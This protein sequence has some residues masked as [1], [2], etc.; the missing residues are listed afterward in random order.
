MM[1]AVMRRPMFQPRI[2]RRQTGTPSTGEMVIEMKQKPQLDDYGKAVINP[3]F[4]NFLLSTYGDR[5][6]SLLDTLLIGNTPENF[7][8][9]TGLLNEFTNFKIANEMKEKGAI[10]PKPF[11]I[12]EQ[13]LNFLERL[14]SATMPNEPTIDPRLMAEGGKVESDAVGIASGLDE[15]TPS[16]DP[17]KDGIA[18]VSPEQYVQLMNDVRGDE[19]SMEGRVQEL[20]GVVGEKDAK[21]TPLS[22]LALV[23]PVFE[24]QEKQGIAQA[25]GAD[26]MMAQAVQPQ[27]TMGPQGPMRVNQGGIVHLA[28]GT[29]GE[30][31]YSGMVG[32]FSKEQMA[33]FGL[34]GQDTVGDA[35]QAGSIFGA[36]AIQDQ[37]PNLFYNVG[38]KTTPQAEY[39][40][41]Q[42]FL[43]GPKK[44][45]MPLITAATLIK[46][47]LALAGGKDPLNVAGDTA[48]T[49]IGA[50]VQEDATQ[51]ALNDKIKMLAFNAANTKNAAL[52]KATTD[53]QI[54]AINKQYDFF[55]SKVLEQIK[56]DAKGMKNPEVYVKLDDNNQIIATEIQD[57]GSTE[58]QTKITELLNNNY[59]PVNQAFKTQKKN[60]YTVSYP[61]TK[62]GTTTIKTEILDLNTPDG[63]AKYNE[64]QNAYLKQEES[65]KKLFKFEKLSGI[66]FSPNINV[67][68][69]NIQ[70]K[71]DGG[72]VYRSTGTDEG[73][74]QSE[75]EVIG[76]S[77]DFLQD[78]DT[79]TPEYQTGGQY[80]EIAKGK[81]K[82][83]ETAME[84]IVKMYQL[85]YDNPLYF[86]IFGSGTRVGK[87]LL[88]AIDDIFNA[89]GYDVDL[90][91]ES[92]FFKPVIDEI[93]GL[94]TAIATS[95]ASVRREQT[96]RSNPVREINLVKNDLNI[97]GIGN[98]Q[99]AMDSLEQAWNEMSQKAND[100]R[101]L[102]PGVEEIDYEVPKIFSAPRKNKNDDFN[103]KQFNLIQSMMPPE[104]KDL[105]INDPDIKNAIKA[106]IEGADPTAVIERLKQL[107]G[108]E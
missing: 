67:P 11:E 41:I 22:V 16:S 87:G 44:S 60:E 20:A 99:R 78:L 28:N 72:I 27:M 106:V 2:V 69:T 74:E 3:E 23:Q 91:M 75:Q 102:L 45:K 107:K 84:N 93:M 94:E 14:K 48:T 62:D 71:K 76:V 31:V 38:D 100:Q 104:L 51:E 96:G 52:T 83:A 6:Q 18:K 85:A 54:N 10:E 5:G 82:Q 81:L 89:F 49:L 29:G 61:V 42:S 79:A 32:P 43:G 105:T 40:N 12:P 30:G 103:V 95:M 37:V 70:D 15:E 59:V 36:Q 56:A 90:P 66:T 1:N 47:G 24:L 17:S 39:A 65:V 63:L 19:V 50:K 8:L 64:L 108:I 9:L 25:P 26:Q 73:G 7:S 21:D 101:A 13:E 68:I 97:T 34:Y 92:F 86:G 55:T 77:D 33:N 46:E 80:T 4:Q 58:G 57:L 88:G 98:A 53:M 35:F